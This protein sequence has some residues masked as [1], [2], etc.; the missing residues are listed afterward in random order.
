MLSIYRVAALLQVNRRL[1]LW[2]DHGPTKSNGNQSRQSTENI[3]SYIPK[4]A[5]FRSAAAV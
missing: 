3:A 1:K 4:P 2:H 5:D